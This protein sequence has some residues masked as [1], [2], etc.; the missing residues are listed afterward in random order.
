MKKFLAIFIVT[1]MTIVL[2]GCS[3]GE[4]KKDNTESG[5]VDSN[6]GKVTMDNAGNQNETTTLPLAS[7]DESET[8][9]NNGEEEATT[10][11]QEETTT[12]K[13]TEQPTP[14]PTQK[15][16]MHSYTES[17]T[18]EATCTD[19]GIKTFSCNCG[20]T[21]TE[22]IKATGHNFEVVADSKVFATCTNSGK[23]SDTKCSFCGDVIEGKVIP[24]IS[25][26]YGEYVYNN[27]ASTEKDGT[28]TATCGNCGNKDTRTVAGT[29]VEIC[30]YNLYTMAYDNQGY[31]YFYGKWGGSANMDADNWAKT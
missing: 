9:S 25:H 20:D 5:I 6:S 31:P 10:L 13:P 7:S 22:V 28:E 4:I 16:H 21:Y 23:E 26:S 17:V 14:T 18:K 29:R 15:P 1:T 11:R 8:T 12:K 19:K 27:D 2:V 24:K 30:P 3:D